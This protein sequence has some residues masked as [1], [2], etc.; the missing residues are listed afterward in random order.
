MISFSKVLPPKPMEVYNLTSLYEGF[1]RLNLVPPF[2]IFDDCSNN[3]DLLYMNWI[4]SYQPAYNDFMSLLLKIQQGIDICILV[5]EDDSFD[6]INESL[7]KLLS[8]R[9]GIIANIINCLED[10]EYIQDVGPRQP[11]HILNMDFDRDK[12]ISIIFKQNPELIK[13]NE[14]E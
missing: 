13:G 4:F 1:Y 11:E 9:Y 2:S 3:L 12:Y 8:E 6:M 10:W 14:E 5:I 7:Q